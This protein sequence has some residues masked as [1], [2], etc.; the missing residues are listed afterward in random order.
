MPEHR[1]RDATGEGLN[2]RRSVPQRQGRGSCHAT[3]DQE[4]RDFGAL[5]AD[6]I[7]QQGGCD[8]LVK[9]LRK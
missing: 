5:R 2:P 8:D 6:Y 7:E 9:A 1:R 4:S 3:G